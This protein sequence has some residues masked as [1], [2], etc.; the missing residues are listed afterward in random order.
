LTQNSPHRH[1]SLMTVIAA[2]CDSC[3]SPARAG[4]Q[5]CTTSSKTLAR[6]IETGVGT[7][8]QRQTG[9][10]SKRTAACGV[11][12]AL[13][14]AVSSGTRLTAHDDDDYGRQAD[15]GRHV[16]ERET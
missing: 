13:T 10:W 8:K 3:R 7:M 9:S 16:F 15:T 2:G 4:R 5:A 1:R 6:G 12:A 11:I 14:I